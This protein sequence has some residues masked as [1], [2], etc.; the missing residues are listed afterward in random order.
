MTTPKRPKTGDMSINS[1]TLHAGIRDITCDIK[2]HMQTQVRPQTRSSALKEE[3][4]RTQSEEKTGNAA[5]PPVEIELTMRAPVGLEKLRS[6]MREFGCGAPLAQVLASRGLQAKNLQSK[7]EITPN[8]GLRRAAQQIQRALHSGKRIRVHG[9]YDADGVTATATLIRG[10]RELGA[11]VHGFIPHRTH[12]GYGINMKRVPEHIQA[13]DLFISVDC[14][15]ANPEE[16]AA[17]KAGGLEVIITDHHAPGEHFPDC[18]VVHPALTQGYDHDQ[19]NLT[20]AGVAYHLLWAVCEL[21][22][23]PAPTHLSAIASIGTIADVAEVTGENRPLIQ[24]GLAEL[25]TTT[26]PGLRALLGEVGKQVSARDV[27]FGIAPRINAAGRLGEADLA[28]ELLLEENVDK[29]GEIAAQLQEM[30]EE[31]RAIQDAMFEQ[32]IEIAD[33]S[34]QVLVITHP[35][36]H[37]GVMG[38]VASKLVERFGKPTFIIAKGKGS[39]RS[40]PGMSA[41]K[42]LKSAEKLLI[43]YGGHPGAA[44]FSIDESNVP[45]L[46]AALEAYAKKHPPQKLQAIIDAPLSPSTLEATWAESQTLEPFGH[47][48]PEPAWHGSGALQAMRLVGGNGMTLQ[49][50]LAGVKGV[51]HGHG[52]LEEGPKDLILNIRRNEWKSKVSYEYGAQLIRDARPLRLSG[53]HPPIPGIQRLSVQAGIDLLRSGN[54]KA[55]GTGSIRTWLLAEGLAVLS[56]DEVQSD[57]LGHIVL[58][59]LP[60]QEIIRHWISSGRM[61]TFAF[62]PKVISALENS[63]SADDAVRYHHLQWAHALKHIDERDF[64]AA[65]Q[66]LIS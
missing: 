48:H 27:G 11:D 59:E 23:Q 45:A 60:D 63:H 53:E 7:L 32:A 3:A 46:K 31:R 5:L 34:G 22:N 55:Y 51:K 8:A 56:E 17:L 19:H 65:V 37:P 43:K 20:G 58:F 42:A 57:T 9:D 64:G 29:A 12:D 40:L 1:T 50:Q 41:V 18:E 44:G 25:S 6:A 66:H 4:G 15:V 62:G 21:E 52:K 39:V 49:F 30:N 16:V 24:R 54:W 14:G 28:L 13:C 10:L 26:I 2:E 61:L 38:I 35:D 47:G 33:L 36:W